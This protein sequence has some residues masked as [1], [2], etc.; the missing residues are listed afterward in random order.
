[1]TDQPEEKIRDASGV[2][3]TPSKVGQARNAVDYNPWI[4]RK[5]GLFE[6]GRRGIADSLTTGKGDDFVDVTV[7]ITEDAI[8]RTAIRASQVLHVADEFAAGFAEKAF[9]AFLTCMLFVFE[10]FSF[11]EADDHCL[12]S[13]TGEADPEQKSI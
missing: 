10:R 9:T 4:S 1:M 13:S 7:G 11:R 2:F 12:I 5:P 8:W 3:P 6:D